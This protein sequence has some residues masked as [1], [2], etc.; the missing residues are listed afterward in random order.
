MIGPVSTPSSTQC[1]VTPV[2][3]APAASASRTACPPGKA[4]SSAGWV[5]TILNRRTTDGAR[6]F[7]KPASTTM[8]GR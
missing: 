1:T 7:M 5:L 6:I 2:D 8:S 3:L 4:G